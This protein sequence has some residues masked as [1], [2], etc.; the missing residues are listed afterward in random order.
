MK[1]TAIRTLTE[2]TCR[3]CG[4]AIKFDPADSQTF[5]TKTEHE[6]FFGMKLMT[7]RV[8][9]DVENE[10]H[11]NSVVVD[12]MGLFRGHRDAFSEPLDKID[13]SIDRIY[14]VLHEDTPAIESTSNIKLAILIN[15]TERWVVDVVCP[16]SVNASEIATLALDRVEEAWRVYN[17]IPQPMETR[18]ADMG[19]HV[20][21]SD[22][23]V[24]C[25]SFRNGS[26]VKAVDALAPHIIS[27]TEDSIIPRRRMLKLIFQILEK[28]PDLTPS[29]LSRIMNEDMLHT[30]FHTPFEDRIPSIVERTATRH[31]IAEDILGPLLRGYITLIEVLEGKA[32]SSYKE[33]FELVDFIN[34]R[35]ILG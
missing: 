13:P 8:S 14:W 33:V 7:F 5:M 29:M 12:H 25:V 15:R 3:I 27:E 28:N 19:L 2:F 21:T 31:P 32:A 18:I 17:T 23:R 11:T 6:D 1:L 10:R 34:R 30:T 20:W 16:K 22:S 24:L 35:K 9:H 4:E 26:L